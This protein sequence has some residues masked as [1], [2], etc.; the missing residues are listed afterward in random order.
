MHW[1]RPGLDFL[2]EKDG[3]G[4]M[5]CW[6]SWEGG[7]DFLRIPLR[8][9]MMFLQIWRRISWAA[10]KKIYDSF[11]HW[12]KIYVNRKIIGNSKQIWFLATLTHIQEILTIDIVGLDLQADGGTHVS[13]T[14]EVGKVSVVVHESKGRINKRLR[15]EVQ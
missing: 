11:I 1:W 6:I 15:I 2:T 3:G 14:S 5:W 4:N 10:H 9:Y 13:R 7:V 8:V 12:T